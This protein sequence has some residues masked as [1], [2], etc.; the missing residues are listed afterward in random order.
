M[1]TFPSPVA[2]RIVPTVSE[3]L[4]KKIQ[5]AIK[6]KENKGKRTVKKETSLEVEEVNF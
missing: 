4:K 6:L 1:E 2:Q 3:D 5:A